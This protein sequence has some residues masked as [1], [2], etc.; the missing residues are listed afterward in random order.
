MESF[1]FCVDNNGRGAGLSN[2]W[3]Y[4]IQTIPITNRV[5]TIHNHQYSFDKRLGTGTFGEVYAA[6]R[7]PDSK[8]YF[9]VMFILKHR[10]LF[11][12]Y[13]QTCCY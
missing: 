13:R 12:L 9:I 8:L 5:V 1:F 11:F 3:R 6:R 2:S 7:L 10:I 4:T